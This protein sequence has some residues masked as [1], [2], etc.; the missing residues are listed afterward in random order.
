MRILVSCLQSRKRHPIPAYEFWRSYFVQG[1]QEAG[2]E[3]LEV[4]GVDWAEGLTY[5][6]GPELESWRARTW[7]ATLA[8]VRREL[9]CRPIGLFISYLFPAQVDGAAIGELQRI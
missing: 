2:H 8:Y 9:Q 6:H 7:D 5:A 1:L 4:P 3:V